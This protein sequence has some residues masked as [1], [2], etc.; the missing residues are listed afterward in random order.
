MLTESYKCS[1]YALLGKR[2]SLIVLV[3]NG[4]V[5]RGELTRVL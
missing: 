3:R 4:F 5:F 1:L 2:E